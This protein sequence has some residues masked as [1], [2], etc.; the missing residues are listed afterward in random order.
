MILAVLN[1]VLS[2]SCSTCGTIGCTQHIPQPIGSVNR[3]KYDVKNYSTND[4]QAYIKGHSI[5]IYNLGNTWVTVGKWL[6]PPC[7]VR[8]ID[9]HNPNFP[10]C[11]VEDICFGKENTACEMITG[12][13]GIEV[14]APV[15]NQL[16][17]TC[18]YLDHP[19]IIKSIGL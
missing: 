5:V 11:E 1:I 4:R 16:E 9:T 7:I 8:V 13:D 10:F 6:I 19:D 18:I 15:R 12:D 2:D 3:S 14:L 17:I